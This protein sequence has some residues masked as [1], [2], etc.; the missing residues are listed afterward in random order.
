MQKPHLSGPTGFKF[1]SGV[2]EGSPTRKRPWLKYYGN[3]P[4]SLEYPEGSLHDTVSATVQKYPG[5]IAYDFLGHKTTYEQLGKDIDQCARGLASLGI[6]AGDRVLISMLTTPHALTAIY[7]INKLGAISTIIHPYSVPKQVEEY[8]RISKS[9][10]VL[11]MDAFYGNFTRFRKMLTPEAMVVVKIQDYLLGSQKRKYQLEKGRSIPKIPGD[12]PI[13]VWFELMQL[14]HPEPPASEVLA[15]DLAV[16]LFS[17]GSSGFPKGILLSNRNINVQAS[18]FAAWSGMQYRSSILNLMPLSTAFGLSACMH[19]MLSVGGRCIL[20]PWF[21]PPLVAKLIQAKQPSHLVAVPAL[22]SNLNQDLTF[23]RSYLGFLKC[24]ISGTSKLPIFVKLRFEEI[25]KNNGGNVQLLESYGLTE[26]AGAICALPLGE[27][28][29][30]SVGIPFPDNLV[31]IVQVGSEP[32]QEVPW[33]EDGEICVN[34]EAVM[35]GYLDQP[36]ETAKALR[37]HPDGLTWLHTGDVASMDEDG[38][39]YFKS[40]L[41]RI[42]QSGANTIYPTQVEDVINKHPDVRESAVVGVPDEREG[43]KIRAFVVLKNSAGGSSRKARELRSFCQ[44][45]LITWNCPQEIYFL[46]RLPRNP[47]GELLYNQ[48]ELQKKRAKL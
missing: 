46:P 40:R 26:T 4:E 19:G 41:K 38:F 47:N 33:G 35:L 20:V 6:Q 8:I 36:G 15:D 24:A 45:R 21:T 7:A 18:Q 30:G 48:L 14:S 29:G 32:P 16:I 34:G 1:E 11:T 9:K 28:R 3:V 43:Q 44:D 2:L 27:Y 25:V 12:L 5:A 17:G 23:L 42:I 37:V 39:I 13:H 10:F 22:F 31:K